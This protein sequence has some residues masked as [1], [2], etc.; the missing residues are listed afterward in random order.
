VMVHD[1]FTGWTPIIWNVFFFHVE[2][3][4]TQTSSPCINMI[5]S[6]LHFR[7]LFHYVHNINVISSFCSVRNFRR[8]LYY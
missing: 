6:K 8:S 2:A 7:V 1:V 3:R 4:G 5:P